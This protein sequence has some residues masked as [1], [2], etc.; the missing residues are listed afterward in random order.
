MIDKPSDYRLD[1]LWEKAVAAA[2]KGDNTGVVFLLRSLGNKGVWQAWAAMGELYESG[3]GNLEKSLNEA[4][5]WYQM[6][7]YEC[8]DPIAHLGMG[9]AYYNGT[10]GVQQDFIKAFFHF[11]KAYLAR[12]PES[13]IY[14][15]LMTNHGIA[16]EKN[17]AKAKEY[18]EFSAAHDFCIAYIH[19]AR[20]EFNAGHIFNAIKCFIKANSLLKKLKKVDP[21]DRRL[22]GVES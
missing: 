12:M 7:I 18:F 9:R 3:G 1:P 6:A 11:Q 16:T 14:M 4:V 21:N 20:I 2:E 8:D 10:G 22:M 5:K 17:I 13:G 15:G 19:L